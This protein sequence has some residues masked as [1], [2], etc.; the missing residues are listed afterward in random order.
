ME[1]DLSDDDAVRGLPTRGLSLQT[2]ASPT[3]PTSTGNTTLTQQLE[4]CMDEYLSDDSEASDRPAQTRG[5]SLLTA[6]ASPTRP[7]TLL[8]DRLS[9]QPLDADGG[10]R[11]LSSSWVYPLD[12][13]AV[14]AAAVGGGIDSG[15]TE[16]P[17]EPPTWHADSDRRQLTAVWVYPPAGNAAAVAVSDGSGDGS[18]HRISGDPQRLVPPSVGGVVPSGVRSGD[19]QPDE[20]R[21]CS[22]A[23]RQHRSHCTSQAVADNGIDGV[24]ISPVV[25]RRT[26]IRSKQPDTGGRYP[27]G[28]RP[29]PCSMQTVIG[30]D[31]DGDGSP[32]TDDRSRVRSKQPDGRGRCPFGR[33]P[34]GASTGSNQPD[35]Q[36]RLPPAKRRRI[37]SKQPDD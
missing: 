22:P 37:T 10:R 25:G 3:R 6:A 34:H 8:S 9:D 23:K 28:C 19:H 1:E 11:Q 26:R 32:P 12:G 24:S 18:P 17:G 20:D 15:S 7:A 4:T 16:H 2:A 21:E 35:E 27:F 31:I 36:V 30:S 5:I 14:A 33:R 13:Q 29:H